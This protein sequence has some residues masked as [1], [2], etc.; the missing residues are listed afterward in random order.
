MRP[1]F[2]CDAMLGHLARWLRLLGFDAEYVPPEMPDGDALARATATGRVLVTRD[3]H[4]AAR[5][6]SAGAVAVEVPRGALEDEL[7]HVLR[8]SG[9]SVDAS[10]WFTRCS[11]CS[12]LLEPV[13]PGEVEGRVPPKV[14]ENRT[15]FYRCPRCGQIY[16]EGTHAPPIRRVLE[17]VAERAS[18]Q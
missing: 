14:M 12:G 7:A 13:T 6:S 16:W 5:A 18:A 1:D 2:L 4:L 3:A 9:A 10:A 8:S 11:R 15:A 17:A